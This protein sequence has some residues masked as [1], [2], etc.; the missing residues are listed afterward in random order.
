MRSVLFQKLQVTILSKV[1]DKVSC[2]DM[3]QLE[4]P[5]IYEKVSKASDNVLNQKFKTIVDSTIFV[6]LNLS[7]FLSVLFV[8]GAHSIWLALI[9]VAGLIPTIIGRILQGK[10][11]FNLYHTQTKKRQYQRYLWELLTSYSVNRD[12]KVFHHGEYLRKEYHKVINDLASE[13]WG[14]EKK[15]FFRAVYLESLQPLSIAIAILLSIYLVCQGEIQ[16]A[17]F[18]A[19]I[20]A[21]I[22]V[23]ETTTGTIRSVTEAVSSVPYLSNFFDYVKQPDKVH[24]DKKQKV[25]SL[26]TIEFCDVSFRYPSAREDCLQHVSFTLH[27]NESIALVGENGSGKSTLVKLLLRIYQPTQGKILLNGVDINEIEEE[28]FYSLISAVLQNFVR[29]KL[30]LRENIAMSD[31]G[32]IDNSELLKKQL[33]TYDLGELVQKLPNG[34]DT[35]LGREFGEVDLSGGQWQKIAI[36]RGGLKD[37][38]LMILDEPT[39]SI[40]PVAESDIFH[41]FQQFTKACCSVII[42]HRIGAARIASRILVLD[43]GKLIEAGSH[44]E[45]MQINGVYHNLYQ[46]QA[47]WYDAV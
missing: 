16:L 14:L 8:L 13:E 39:A 6:P 10:G 38:S 36:A 20:Q 28:S 5:E 24:Q 43:H 18:A 19:L 12:I 9:A 46:L 31:L 33:E 15:N 11:Y 32:K 37:C 21:M 22:S 44:Q 1:F 7:C 34:L 29:Y 40:D 26:D 23:N 35:I 47:Q 42:S 41:K 45:L 4:K 27:G 25:D 3:T 17:V 2:D 30:S